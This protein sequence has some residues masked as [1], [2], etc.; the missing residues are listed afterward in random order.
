[1]GFKHILLGQL[2]DKERSGY[3]LHKIIPW[4]PPLSQIYRTLS[5]MN[6][7]GLV[8]FRVET[9]KLPNQNIYSITDKGLSSLESWLRKPPKDR[10]PYVKLQSQ[11]WWADQ[12]DK[13]YAVNN[14]KHFIA[15]TRQQLDYYVKDLEP[16]L[17]E[18]G[19]D[20]GSKLSYI[21]RKLSGQYMVDQCQAALKW[22][23]KALK[24]LEDF[25]E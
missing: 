22:A 21:Y 8:R 12:V 10:I 4:H 7:D 14:I 25:K 18:Y 17:D 23:D 5:S 24:E 19:K 1:M 9:G 20:R 13:K 2:S 11:L 16:K 3:A 15:Q 6:S